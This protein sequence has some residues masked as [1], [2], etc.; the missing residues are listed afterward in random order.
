MFLWC[1]SVQNYT[2]IFIAYAMHA[3]RDIILA[4][5]IRL[6]VHLSVRH[7]LVLYLRAVLEA[8]QQDRQ[9]L[10]QPYPETAPDSPPRQQTSP[11]TAGDITHLIPL[12][13]LQRNPRRPPHVDTNPTPTCTERRP[14][15]AR[16]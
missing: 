3:E 10:L 7:I 4:K 9:C 6:S 5:S 16:S 15:R 11:E 13:L 2:S 12:G 14:T 1:L 8:R